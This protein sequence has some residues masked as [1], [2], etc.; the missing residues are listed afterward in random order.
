[1]AITISLADLVVTTAGTFDDAAQVVHIGD[2]DI[3]AVR[4]AD[5]KVL[6]LPGYGTLTFI[7]DAPNHV[8][9][10]G[11][12]A[13]AGGE[14]AFESQGSNAIVT[15]ADFSNVTAAVTVNGAFDEIIGGMGDDMLR[16]AAYSG[17]IIQGGAG[18]DTITIA[19]FCGIQTIDAGAG[20]DLVQR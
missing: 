15:V 6:T 5:G 2:K 12:A 8:A 10:Q 7:N 18:N 14:Y 19:D 16:G 13:L 20:D 3:T 4:S 9:F 1:M 17:K 11:D